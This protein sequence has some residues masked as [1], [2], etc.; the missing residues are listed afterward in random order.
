[1]LNLSKLPWLI[2]MWS[3][4]NARCS[5]SSGRRVWGS[6]GQESSGRASTRRLRRSQFRWKPF[7]VCVVAPRLAA[8]VCTRRWMVRICSQVARVWVRCWSMRWY[9][10]A[11]CRFVWPFLQLDALQKLRAYGRRMRRLME[12]FAWSTYKSATRKTT[13]FVWAKGPMLLPFRPGAGR[14]RFSQFQVGCGSKHGW[15]VPATML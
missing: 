8:L 15:R 10:D 2:G 12:P 9:S 11:R 5:M 14:A 4:V 7:T 6:F 13:N 3:A 1:M